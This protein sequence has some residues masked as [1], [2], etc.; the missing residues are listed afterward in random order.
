MA[1]E[2]WPDEVDPPVRVRPARR[3]AQFEREIE[4]GLRQAPAK[5]TSS[6]WW[7]GKDREALN[8]EAEERS[9]SMSAS[10][11]ATKVSA[12]RGIRMFSE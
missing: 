7:L 6:S 2:D 3:Q 11:L 10:K 9:A 5:S 12:A 4:Q 1:P 8:R